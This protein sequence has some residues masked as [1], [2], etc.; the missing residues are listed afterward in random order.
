[1]ANLPFTYTRQNYDICSRRCRLLPSQYGRFLRLSGLELPANQ[2]SGRHKAPS[3]GRDMYR[4]M[5]LDQ[6]TSL[7]ECVKPPQFV[8]HDSRWNESMNFHSKRH[9][10]FLHRICMV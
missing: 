10:V 8:S 2:N 9:I 6:F 4:Y 7:V 1:M 5:S 3:T